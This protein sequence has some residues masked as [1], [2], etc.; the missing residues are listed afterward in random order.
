MQQEIPRPVEPLDYAPPPPRTSRLRDL[1]L[2]IA[3][4]FFMALG[5]GC[6][7]FGLLVS[8]GGMRDDQATITSAGAA[9]ITLAFCLLALMFFLRRPRH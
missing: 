6:F 5:V 2:G 3:I 9:F 8:R 7:F 1:L 4:S